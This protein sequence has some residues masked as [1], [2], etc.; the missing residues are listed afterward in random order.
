M[1]KDLND[2][3]NGITDT[4]NEID[5]IDKLIADYFDSYVF[6]KDSGDENDIEDE[7]NK[8]IEVDDVYEWLFE[9]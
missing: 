9:L 3:N 6:S 2:I 7:L 5:Y 4:L 1:N 8:M